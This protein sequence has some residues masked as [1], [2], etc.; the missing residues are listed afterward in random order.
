MKQDLMA[1]E[2]AK[3]VQERKA[4][5][6]S[7]ALQRHKRETTTLRTA[8][9]TADERLQ[10]LKAQLE[11]LRPG[12]GQLDAFKEVV[13]SLKGSVEHYRTQMTELRNKKDETALQ[14]AGTKRALDTAEAALKEKQAE[15]AKAQDRVQKYAT[16]RQNTL[17]HKNEADATRNDAKSELERLRETV[18]ELQA[19]L[20]TDTETA[21]G[22]SERIPVPANETKESLFKK[23]DQLKKR[24]EETK[25]RIGG[26]EAD[27]K[28]ALVLATK[29]VTSFDKKFKMETAHRDML[30][31]ALMSRR[32]RWKRFRT[33]I[34]V[35]ARSNF[36]SLLA[37]RR[38]RGNMV[39]DHRSRQLQLLVEP[40]P[41][42]KARSAG[43]KTTALSGGERSFTTLCMLLALWDAMGSPI[44]CLDEFDVYMDA[45]NRDMSMKMLIEAA[46]SSV[47]R[48]YV[49]ITPQAMNNAEADSAVRCIRLEDPER[50]QST[51]TQGRAAITRG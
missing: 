10:D 5:E 40:D 16:G 20:A 27:L 35:R 15:I 9:Q 34:S 24:W 50:G 48:Q 21:R 19:L 38:F 49:F 47:G 11:Q 29:R 31:S 30:H 7:Q 33:A 18:A 37:E 36:M 17:R 8:E 32:E 6:G 2:D 14:N 44:R 22:I 13:E 23:H 12:D 51:L 42:R 43:S 1:S 26:S 41:S 3:R 39:I 28:T 45:A 46:K 25:A 4:V